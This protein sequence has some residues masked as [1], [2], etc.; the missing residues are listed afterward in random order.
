MAIEQFQV[1]KPSDLIQEQ[2]QLV[3]P[4]SKAFSDS[5]R[6]AAAKARRAKA[7]GRPSAGGAGPQGGSHG[8]ASPV[9]AYTEAK[10]GRGAGQT[11]GQK[12]GSEHVAAAGK[13]SSDS[14]QR[15]VSNHKDFGDY[16]KHQATT[17]KAAMKAFTTGGK[18]ARDK[19]LADGEKEREKKFPELYALDQKASKS[20]AIQQAD[21]AAKFRKDFDAM[22]DQQKK[23]TLRGLVPSLAG[24]RQ[25]IK[26]P[27]RSAHLDPKASHGT[28]AAN[29]AKKYGG[30][31]APRS[32]TNVFPNS[33]ISLPKEGER[34]LVEDLKAQG[35][36]EP[37]HVI[38]GSGVYEKDGR[39]VRVDKRYGVSVY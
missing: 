25:E 1:L 23:D 10:G 38:K 16:A 19:V 5:A 13:E 21:L 2:P 4:L 15:E 28:L 35:W 27:L 36:K 22:T 37:S 30:V 11:P 7:A 32:S 17:T 6:I 29:I 9:N 26:P 3:L 8:G 24:R 20:R 14:L 39:T 33:Q 34:A 12:S 18:E 31:K